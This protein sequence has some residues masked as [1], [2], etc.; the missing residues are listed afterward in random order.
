MTT[1]RSTDLG[2][3]PTRPL[4]APLPANVLDFF[5]PPRIPF[6]VS[7][8]AVLELM[9]RQRERAT[10]NAV[11]RHERRKRRRDTNTPVGLR[12]KGAGS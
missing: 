1:R 11:A 2:V 3:P 6:E 4:E 12:S 10:E 5:A 8:L 9:Q 7:P